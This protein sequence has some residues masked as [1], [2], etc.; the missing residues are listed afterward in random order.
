MTLKYEWKVS[1]KGFD[2]INMD[3]DRLIASEIYYK[4]NPDGIGNI[5]YVK[6]SGHFVIDK[7]TGLVYDTV[8]D[9]VPK[10]AENKYLWVVGETKEGGLFFSTKTSQF[11][12]ADNYKGYKIVLQ[13]WYKNIRQTNNQL[14]SV[15]IFKDGNQISENCLPRIFD[16]TYDKNSVYIYSDTDIYK[17]NFDELI[18]IDEK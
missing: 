10:T 7:F 1:N 5:Q 17:F 16:F 11:T 4:D 15:L 13:E 8:F 9:F 6:D 2:I 12:V 14:N 3:N 18:K